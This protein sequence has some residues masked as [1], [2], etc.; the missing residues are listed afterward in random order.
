MV[1]LHNSRPS[2]KVSALVLAML[3]IVF[4]AGAVAHSHGN[5]HADGACQVCHAG[6]LSAPQQ[7]LPQ[8]LFA[9]L[10]AVGDVRQFVLSVHQES[11][12]R[13]SASRAPPS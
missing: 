13:E 12:L 4:V 6:H 7:A 3:F 11:F 10:I 1:G 9:P 8:G 2:S 5:G